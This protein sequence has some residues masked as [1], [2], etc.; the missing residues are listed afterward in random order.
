MDVLAKNKI[1]VL[2]RPE[3]NKTELVHS[4]MSHA[5]TATPSAATFAE[6]AKIEWHMETRYYRAELEFW[7]DSTERLPDAHIQSMQ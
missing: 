1:L 3:V 6:S 5:S 7:V 2:G 4:I